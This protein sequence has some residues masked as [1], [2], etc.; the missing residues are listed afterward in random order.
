MFVTLNFM[1]ISKGKEY[2]LVIYKY[3]EGYSARNRRKKGNDEHGM[4]MMK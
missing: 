4:F 2:V 1:F 3:L